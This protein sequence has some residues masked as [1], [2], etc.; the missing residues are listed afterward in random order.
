MLK[1]I[2]NIFAAN[3]KRLRKQ[4]G[5]KSQEKLGELAGVHRQTIA[6]IEL[7]QLPEQVT[8][9][10]IAK[11]L[12]VSESELFRGENIRDLIPDDIAA[13]IAVADENQLFVIRSVL[14]GVFSPPPLPG[15]K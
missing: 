8:I 10:A 15:K 1:T 13:Q 14:R 2:S 7:G 4:K 12:G 3:L 11:A 9:T 5:I 6:R